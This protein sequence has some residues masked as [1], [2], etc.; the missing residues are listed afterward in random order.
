MNAVKGSS[1]KLVWE[2]G[3]KATG[4]VHD[5]S[6]KTEWKLKGRGLAYKGRGVEVRGRG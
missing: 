6:K 2:G 1:E 5:G 3:C 4:T